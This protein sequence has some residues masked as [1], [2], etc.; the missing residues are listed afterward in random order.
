MRRNKN[1]KR[2]GLTDSILAWNKKFPRANDPEYT[3]GQAID[4]TLS[5]ALAL[6]TRNLCLFLDGEL[7]A[8]LLFHEAIDGKHYIINH[9]KVDYTIPFIFD[10]MTCQIA[11]LAMD[12]SIP[13][14]NIEMDLGIESLRQHKMGLRP[15]GFFKKYSI[16]L[17]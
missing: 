11:K 13:F 5:S 15:A 3:E 9:L 16:G 2:Q 4:R 6:D 12:N 1:C 7:Q 17:K 14:L 10:F 8:V